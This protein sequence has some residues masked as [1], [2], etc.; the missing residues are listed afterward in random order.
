MENKAKN[1]EL[2]NT[3][4]TQIENEN[5]T[6]VMVALKLPQI[7]LDMLC[8]LAKKDERPDDVATRIIR[9]K[10]NQSKNGDQTFVENGIQYEK[11]LIDLPKKVLDFYRCYAYAQGKPDH[12]E[13]FIAI[14]VCD[15]LK[16]EIEN[17]TP[18]Q[19]A[20]LFNLGASFADMSAKENKIFKE[21]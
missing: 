16:T 15:N 18:E 7:E 17:K 12:A 2:N 19:W 14:D 21:A 8:D 20:Q 6:E 9:E 4:Q 13:T 11:A 10:L 3:Q 1:K 5:F